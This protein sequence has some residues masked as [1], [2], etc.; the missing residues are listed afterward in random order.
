MEEWQWNQ[1]Y[2]NSLLK[3]ST[4]KRIKYEDTYL[5]IYKYLL[6]RRFVR[7]TSIEE[8]KIVFPK[9]KIKDT[10]KYW[11]IIYSSGYLNN[12]YIFNALS[13]YGLIVSLSEFINIVR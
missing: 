5:D 3:Y 8:L 6:D 11:Y 7:K 4:T 12:N 9:C 1:L 10:D 13:S 2:I